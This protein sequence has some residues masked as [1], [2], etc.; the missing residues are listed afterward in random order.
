M[1]SQDSICQ[2]IFGKS[3]FNT[4]YHW[5]D[6]VSLISG[7]IRTLP[8]RIVFLTCIVTSFFNDLA[9]SDKLLFAEKNVRKLKDFASSYGRWLLTVTKNWQ[10]LS[11]KISLD[12]DIWWK[13]KHFSFNLPGQ[14]LISVLTCYKK[15][16]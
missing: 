13:K 14:S 1:S 9:S 15:Y 7:C 4:P 5:Y 10:F 8:I 6:F 11:H 16:I 12:F 3:R 2:V